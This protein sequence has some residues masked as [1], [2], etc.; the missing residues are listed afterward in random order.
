M[1]E[2]GLE[3]HGVRRNAASGLLMLRCLA[4]DVLQ[5]LRAVWAPCP[6]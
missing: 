3:T 6:G 4:D 1:Q 2:G 5:V